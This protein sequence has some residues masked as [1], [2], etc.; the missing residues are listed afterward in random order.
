VNHSEDLVDHSL[1]MHVLW[2]AVP[3]VLLMC[4][5]YFM[6]S[7][8]IPVRGSVVSRQNDAGTYWLIIGF[9]GLLSIWLLGE[10]MFPNWELVLLDWIWS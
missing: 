4:V 6:W 7:G 1:T 10:W 8:E 5:A 3:A 2:L 9:F